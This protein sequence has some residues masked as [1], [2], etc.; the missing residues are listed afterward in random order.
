MVVHPKC[1]PAV[2]ATCGLPTEYVRHFAD[3]MFR[4]EEAEMQSSAE[5]VNIK[6]EGWL[7]VPRWV[8]Y[9]APCPVNSSHRF[10]SV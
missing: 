3:M 9:S 10:I 8:K 2:P 6:M 1:A 5:P 7:K 4:I